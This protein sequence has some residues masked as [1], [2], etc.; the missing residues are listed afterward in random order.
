[1]KLKLVF[2]ICLLLSTYFS[3][4]AQSISE[5]F[6][7][8]LLMTSN[9]YTSKMEFEGGIQVYA[10]HDPNVIYFYLKYNTERSKSNKNFDSTAQS[11]LINLY[12]YLLMQNM[13]R[14]DIEF[15][16]LSSKYSVND[17]S[18][19]A[20]R[21]LDQI[22]IKRNIPKLENDAGIDAIKES[23]QNYADY[24]VYK[25]ISND[26]SMV[27]VPSNDYKV[28]R[29][30]LEESEVDFFNHT[31]HNFSSAHFINENEAISKAI[32][33]AF[34]FKGSGYNK[35][36]DFML[37]DYLYKLIPLYI[38]S[39]KMHRFVIGLGI[40]GINTAMNISSEQTISIN[41]RTIELSQLDYG[42]PIPFNVGVSY[43]WYLSDQFTPF[44]FLNVGLNLTNTLYLHS[45]TV[46]VDKVD[47]YYAKVDVNHSYY[48]FVEYHRVIENVDLKSVNF[49]S[50][51]TRLTTPLFIINNFLYI[52]G[53]IL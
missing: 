7:N 42:N 9:N 36:T 35:Q 8:E 20:I 12:R 34:L 22:K 3:V 5:L 21:M 10:S 25:Y 33:L 13:T 37:S 16:N 53:W 40:S 38:Q 44:S 49:T 1:M 32:R 19:L 30:N 27:Y 46:V 52:N 14:M 4:R 2:L 39:Q 24:L 11:K 17:S 29:T 31:Y 41:K 50:V 18:L 28:Y 48:D 26:R 47:E 43:R 45:S 6:E 51:E 23:D 15:K